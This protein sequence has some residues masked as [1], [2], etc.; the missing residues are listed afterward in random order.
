MS[1]FQ[2]SANLTVDTSNVYGTVTADM[3]K[4]EA[5]RVLRNTATQGARVTA[6]EIT[7]VIEAEPTFEI[8]QSD[9]DQRI[10]DAVAA[11]LAAQVPV[12]A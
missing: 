6:V 12:N 1:K 9:L 11:A 5:A 7:D 4:A 3:V 8:T 10:A 2:V